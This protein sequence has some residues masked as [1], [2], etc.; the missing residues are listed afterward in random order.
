MSP[1]KSALMIFN[2]GRIDPLG[3]SI[4]L[5]GF[6]IESVHSYKFLGIYLD[7]GLRGYFHASYLADKCGKLA[8]VLKSLRGI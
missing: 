4:A 6:I 2:R 5:N 3:Y 1:T 7:S 8:N